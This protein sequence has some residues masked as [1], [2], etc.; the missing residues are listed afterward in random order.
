MQ[1]Q[2]HDVL[3]IGAGLSGI[4]TACHLRQK[5]PDRDFAILERRDRI[6]GT[7]DLFRYP[8]I[9]SD[10]DMFSFG[11]SFRPWNGFKVLADGESIR[12]Y[13]SDTAGEYGVTDKIH[14]GVDLQ[15]ANW[16]SKLQ[17]WELRGEQRGAPVMYTSDFLISCTGYYDYRQGYLPPLP[18]IEQFGG[19]VIHPQQWPED[20]DYTGKRIVVIGSGATAVT[21]VPALTDRAAH[22]T[23]LQRSPTYVLSV[24]AWDKISAVLEKFL[25]K[26]LVYRMARKRNIKLHRWIFKAARRWPTLTRRLMLRGVRRALGKN[27]DMRHFSPDYLPWDQ[28]LCAVPDGDLFEAIRSGLAS[29]ETDE[30]AT[31]T[32]DGIR[33]KS[34][35]ELAADIVI[36]AT[37]LKVQVLGGMDLQVDGQSVEINRRLTYKGVLMEGVPNMGWVFGYTNA[38]WTLK[39]DLSADYL[40]RLLNHMQK[41]QQTVFMPV[42]REGCKDEESVMAALKSGYVQRADHLLPR[43]GTKYPWRLVNDYERDA[44]ILLESPIED[45][46]LSFSSQ[47]MRQ[48]PAVKAPAPEACND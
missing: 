37:G 28:R 36:T 13:I 19:Q 42:D 22:V 8:G 48:D 25:P 2:H 14:F 21:L 3:I 9:R 23:M 45:G 43:Q 26:S 46:I 4:G 34:G 18:G 27:A 20:L 10:S 1:T 16:N 15:E 38:A 32:A 11:F 6:G 40:C 30:I 24:P 35:K 33:L 17:R 41:E 29:V 44:R 47:A 39:A 5:S 7:W 12:R 31:F